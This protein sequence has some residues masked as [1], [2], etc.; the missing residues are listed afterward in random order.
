MK[1]QFWSLGK[2]H[3]AYVKEGI[4]MFTQR[5]NH[6]F[7][8]DWKIIP[9]PKNVATLPAEEQKNK[10]AA[11]ILALLKK[12]DYLVLLDER[13]KMLNNESL[14]Q[15]IQARANESVKTIVFLIGGAFGVN[16]AV[17]QRA[18][19]TWS[20]SPLVFPHQL[21]RL[22]LAEQIYRSCTILKNEKYHH[23]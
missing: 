9:Q 11:S 14:A 21:I 4:A 12:D 1:I 16:D 23:I 2:N 18:N 3:E 13:G 22:M 8:T 19:F 6:Y 15:L 5:L 7:T 17:L 10:E 20:L